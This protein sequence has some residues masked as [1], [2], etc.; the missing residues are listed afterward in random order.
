MQAKMFYCAVETRFNNQSFLPCKSCSVYKANDDRIYFKCFSLQFW[1]LWLA[2]RLLLMNWAR[3]QLKGG[4]LKQ[5]PAVSP[6]EHKNI[7]LKKI[8]CITED[9]RNL[10]KIYA[11]SFMSTC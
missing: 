8:F 9:K 11:I 6:K 2:S 5:I 3:S 7:L 1:F 10:S 4:Q